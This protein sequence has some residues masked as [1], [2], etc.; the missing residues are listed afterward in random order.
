MKMC[1]PEYCLNCSLRYSLFWHKSFSTKKFFDRSAKFKM[2]AGRL[3]K[4]LFYL[5]EACGR[6]FHALFKGYLFVKVFFAQNAV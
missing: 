6:E 4:V 2:S 3:V 1:V 5:L